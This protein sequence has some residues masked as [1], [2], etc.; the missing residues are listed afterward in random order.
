MKGGG[1]VM[2]P[3]GTGSARQ[4]HKKRSGEELRVGS[5]H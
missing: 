3:S 1:V 2:A 4:R 5:S